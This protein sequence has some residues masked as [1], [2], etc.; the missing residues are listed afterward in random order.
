MQ[1]VLESVPVKVTND[2][3]AQL[4]AAYIEKE[5]KTS[6]YQMFPTKASGPDGFPAHFF[7]NIGV[8]VEKKSLRPFW[9]PWR[10]MRVRKASTRHTWC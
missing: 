3:H 4:D 7:K 8:F 6:L 9:R 1:E 10:G 5:V 2:M